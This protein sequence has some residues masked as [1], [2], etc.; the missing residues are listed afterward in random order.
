M[1]EPVAAGTDPAWLRCAVH[2]CPAGLSRPARFGS[3]SPVDRAGADRRGACRNRIA[4]PG[5]AERV[6]TA[7]G[8]RFVLHVH[9]G[10]GGVVLRVHQEA[11][12]RDRESPDAHGG[13][14]R[15]RAHADACPRRVLAHRELQRGDRHFQPAALEYG[16]TPGHGYPC[17][18]QSSHCGCPG[19]AGISDHAPGAWRT[20]RK[21]AAIRHR[22][23]HLRG[24]RRMARYPARAHGAQSGPERCGSRLQGNQAATA[25]GDRS[26]PRRRSRGQ[27]RER[28]AHARDPARLAAGDQAA[29]ERRGIRRD[30]RGA[31]RNQAHRREPGEHIRALAEQRR[32]DS[33]RQPGE[34]RGICRCRG[35]QPLQSHARNH[36]R[37]QP[38]GGLCAR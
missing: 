6:C 9:Q 19:R 18:R 34:H 3:A 29:A 14:R 31:R 26:R 30:P 16:T 20:L 1:F 21:T 32:A 13:R 25:R 24:A 23:R 10:P 12:G 22:W 4:L 15:D 33:A 37:G 36:D 27:C 2:A 28:G 5:A 11:R 17:G 35:A 7:R 38:G 8:S